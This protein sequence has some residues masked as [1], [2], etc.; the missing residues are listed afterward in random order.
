MNDPRF[1]T[2]GILTF[3]LSEIYSLMTGFN[4]HIYFVDICFISR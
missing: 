1:Q 4:K 3:R 2:K